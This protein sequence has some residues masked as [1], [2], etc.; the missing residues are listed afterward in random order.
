MSPSTFLSQASRRAA[1]GLTALAGLAGCAGGTGAGATTT[2]VP[3]ATATTAAPTATAAPSDTPQPTATATITVTP[4]PSVLTVTPKEGDIPCRYGP[5]RQYS[6]ENALLAGKTVPVQGRDDAAAWIKIEHPSR[7]GWNCWIEAAAAVVDGDLARAPV[8]AAPEAFVESVFIATHSV[9]L[10]GANCTFPRS[11]EVI[12]YMTTNGP[13]R[14]VFQRARNGAFTPAETTVFPYADTKQYVNVYTL[15]GPGD[16]SI[17]VVVSSPN[18][19]S[20]AKGFSV[21]CA[22]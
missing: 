16:Y 21:T 4:T 20:E 22:P 5:G 11:F 2:S 12:F 14:V 3:T 13:A 15:S 18:G 8:V 1:S 17:D 6:V 7:P 9:V 10:R 19:V